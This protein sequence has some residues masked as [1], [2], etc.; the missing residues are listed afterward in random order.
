MVAEGPPE[1]VREHLLEPAHLG[2]S[3]AADQSAAA[4]TRLRDGGFVVQTAGSRLWIDTPPGRKVE[5]IELLCRAGVRI[6]D[7]DLDGDREQAGDPDRN[8]V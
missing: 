7:F 4:V 5:A 6:L 8:E 1:R 2:L 3:I